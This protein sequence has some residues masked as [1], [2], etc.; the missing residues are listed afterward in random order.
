MIK[1]FRKIRFNALSR[2]R[3][4]K[5]L[6]YA[7]GEIILVVIG[8]LIALQIN[9]WNEDRKQDAKAKS[10]LKSMVIDLN[11]DIENYTNFN[12]S[13]KKEVERN[14][15]IF[16]N[17]NYKEQSIDTI[18][19]LISSTF[20]N[21]K[22]VDQTYQKIKNS[23]LSDELGFTELNNA[24][25]KYYSQD[26]VDY[27][28]FID[29]DKESIVKGIDFWNDTDDYEI[30]TTNGDNDSELPFTDTEHTRKQAVIKKIESNRGRN[31]LRKNI[32]TK[33]WGISMT[34]RA[35]TQAKVLI[36]LINKELEQK[37]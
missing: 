16:K 9:N 23:G 24:I 21:Y 31:R 11:S 4:P 14:S 13:F 17:K 8:I 29:Y 15:T 32:G 19:S 30:N 12:E 22:V 7:T 26:V 27:A 25:N 33:K 18:F 37:K 35:R 5:Y 6:I 3:V 28:T 36:T 20:G 2:K 1:L 34:S 10:Y